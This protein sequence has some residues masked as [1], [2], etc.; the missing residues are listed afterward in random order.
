MPLPNLRIINRTLPAPVEVSALL[1]ALAVV[2][3]LALAS[4][5]SAAF[6]VIATFV[7]T[8]S[9]AAMLYARVVIVE[10]RTRRPEHDGAPARH[11]ENP[12]VIEHRND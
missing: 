6:R 4:D 7:G 9:I 10:D 3:L 11:A 12:V 1:L 8:A 5:A 2:L